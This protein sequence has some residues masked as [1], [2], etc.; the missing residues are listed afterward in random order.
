MKT[1]KLSIKIEKMT[2]N[3]VDEIFKLYSNYA[4][5][6]EIAKVVTVREIEEK[7]Y[8]LSAKEIYILCNSIF[9]LN[10]T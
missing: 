5:V 3:D 2:T 6:E 8:I 7:D 9:I 10:N 1:E 4:D